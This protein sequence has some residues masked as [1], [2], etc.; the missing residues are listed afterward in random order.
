MSLVLPD[1]ELGLSK[2]SQLFINDSFEYVATVEGSQFVLGEQLVGPEGDC[3]FGRAT[4][5]HKARLITPMESKTPTAGEAL[6]G[7][8]HGP[9]S[10]E[11]HKYC[12]K[13]S[14]RDQRRTH[15]G[16]FSSAT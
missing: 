7:V 14:L 8:T 6:Q 1:D 12:F 2:S 16:L 5:V 3:L 11:S 10:E 9:M 13:S 4:T 15:E